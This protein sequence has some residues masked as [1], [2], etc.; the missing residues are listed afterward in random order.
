MAVIFKS[1]SNQ[2]LRDEYQTL[3]NEIIELSKMARDPD[4][5]NRQAATLKAANLYK[6]IPNDLIIDKD[7]HAEQ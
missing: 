1:T 7:K 6:K 5:Q 4:L 2:T 3:R